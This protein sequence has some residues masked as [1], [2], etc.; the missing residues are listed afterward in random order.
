MMRLGI[1]LQ[2]GYLIILSALVILIGASTI[3]GLWAQNHAHN[4]VKARR[5]SVVN[6]R[7]RIGWW[8]IVIFS[9]AWWFG[10]GALTVLF[11]IF[12]FFLLREFIALTPIKNTDHWVLVLAFYIVIPVQYLLVYF[13]WTAIFTVFIP[14]YV[15]LI[16]PVIAAISNDT[17]RYLE[18]IAKVQWGIMICVFCVS[19]APAVATLDLHRYNSSGTLMLLYLLIVTFC[20]DIVS[21]L[22]SSILGGKPLHMNH[23]KSRIG[24]TVGSVAAFAVGIALYWITPFR[25]WQAALYS[26]AI[27]LSCL[28]GELV[29]GSIKRSLGSRSWEGEMYIGRGIIER[30]APLTFSAP[31]FYHLTVLFF[32]VLDL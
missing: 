1:S 31:V 15:F 10:L 12:S 17:E 11:A 9:V 25:L 5:L 30:F 21:V 27:V 28:M 24:V 20:A 23:N 14:I 13:E 22:A 8:L 7:V 32:L 18:R 26:L 2:E 6:S 16:M 29:I 4:P 19:M 3:Y